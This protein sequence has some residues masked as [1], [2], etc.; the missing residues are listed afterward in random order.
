MKGDLQTDWAVRVIKAIWDFSSAMWKARCDTIHGTLEGKTKS[1]RRKELI[2]QIRIE[3]TRTENHADHTTRQLRK[4]I[5]K[6]MGNA[7]TD[8][9][10]VWLDMLRNVKGETFFRKKI[11]SIRKTRAQPITNFFRRAEGT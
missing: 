1:A 8:A 6:S 3:L 4:N 10:V 9:L 5:E 2:D 11:D 7:K